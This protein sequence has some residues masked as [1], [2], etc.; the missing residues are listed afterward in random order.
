MRS[1]VDSLMTRVLAGS[2][3]GVTRPRGIGDRL[4]DPRLDADAVVGDRLVH[5]RHLQ[6]RHRDALTDRHVGRTDAAP[7]I[8]VLQDARALTGQFDA[9]RAADAERAQVVLELLVAH[10]AGQH[11]RADVAGLGEDPG[12]G[13]V[14]GRVVVRVG[15]HP[16]AGLDVAVH[17]QHGLRGGDALLQ[18]GGQ[19]SPPSS[20]EPGSKTPETSG[21]PSRSGSVGR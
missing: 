7:L 18:G 12:H 13:P 3:A 10:L 19:R 1:A 15:D 2:G 9:G 14:D 17:A 4:D 11:D 21:L 20:T 8:G 6:G 5:R 16:V